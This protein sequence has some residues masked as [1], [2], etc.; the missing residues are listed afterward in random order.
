MRI[1]NSIFTVIIL[2]FSLQCFADKLPTINPTATV[3]KSDG[4]EV[5]TSYSGSAPLKVV[6]EANAE[7]ADGWSAYYEWRFTHEEETTP[8]L[9]RYDEDTDYTCSSILV[10]KIAAK[11]FTNS[12]K[13]TLPS[14]VK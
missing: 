1:K 6:F 5:V 3:E 9:I 7:N 4:N 14:A 13:S 12:L 8:Y 10:L 11:S 2:L